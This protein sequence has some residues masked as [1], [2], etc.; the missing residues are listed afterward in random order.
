MGREFQLPDSEKAI[1]DKL[2]RLRGL[3]ECRG[4]EGNEPVTCVG[5]H[6]VVHCAGGSGSV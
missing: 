2:F 5:R 4:S 6:E 3:D 1:C